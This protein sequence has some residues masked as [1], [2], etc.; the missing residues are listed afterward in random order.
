[1]IT[2]ICLK[3]HLDSFNL[4]MPENSSMVNTR[5][6]QHL[7]DYSFCVLYFA[8]WIILMSI[9]LR[10]RLNFLFQLKK[11]RLLQKGCLT[12]IDIYNLHKN[13][14][15]SFL[16]RIFVNFIFRISRVFLY[17]STVLLLSSAFFSLSFVCIPCQ[18]HLPKAQGLFISLPGLMVPHPDLGCLS[19]KSYLHDSFLHI[20]SH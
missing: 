17:F 6:K 16:S 4:S 19:P 5:V 3:R 9:V 1:M 2:C 18:R 15:L 11:I 13:V 7:Y 8:G 14:F 20:L 10:L 12:F